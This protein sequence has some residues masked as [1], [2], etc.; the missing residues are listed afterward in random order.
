MS[1]SKQKRYEIEFMV[2][3]KRRKAEVIGYDGI[4]SFLKNELKIEA[5]NSAVNCWI[6]IKIPKKHSD[7]LLS[8]SVV[9]A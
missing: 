8:I 2:E 4:V 9:D 6:N 1:V 7:I 5:T 3:K